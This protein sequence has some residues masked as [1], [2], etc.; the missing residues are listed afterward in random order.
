MRTTLALYYR[1]LA[2]KGS[3]CPGDSLLLAVLIPLGW[4]YGVVNFIRAWLY[5]QGWLTSYRS[6]VPVISVGNLAVGGTGKTPLVDYLLQRQIEGGRRVAVVSRGY[7][8][9]KG[10]AVRV[11]CAGDGP[12][13][14]AQQCGDEPYLLAWRNPEAVVIIAPQRSVGIR[15][16][17]ERF[18][19]D[20]VLLD[21]GYQ[22]LA[23]QRDLNL[24]LRD[25]GCPFGNGHLLPAGLLREFVSAAARADLY[26]FTRYKNHELPLLPCAKPVV[27][28]TQQLANGAQDLLGNDYSLE[29]LRQ[30][31]CVAFAGIASPDDFF[32]ALAGLGLELQ[33]TL[34]LVDHCEFTPQLVE[35]LRD[36]AD[37]ADFLLTTEKD[38][39][40]LDA[41]LFNIPCCSFALIF[42]PLEADVLDQHVEALF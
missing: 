4:L 19:V 9:E 33:A 14:S 42:E 32:S 26:I 8:S 39:V 5:R 17:V 15:Y 13:L 30:G 28:A 31:R 1:R 12:L 36:L 6:P 25:S 11:V 35:S 41:T 22:H 18:A 7:G 23:V 10:A 21:D 20:L 27:L 40:K 2:G 3:Q 34:P 16:A 38:A 29:Q 37:G 24:L